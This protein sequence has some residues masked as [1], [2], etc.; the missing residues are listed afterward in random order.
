MAVKL[1][2]ARYG[3]KKYAYY[4]I[5]AADV[6]APRDGRFL[7]QIGTYN[8]NDNPATITLK[9]ERIKHWLSQGATPS[10]TVKNLLDTHLE[11]Q[12]ATEAESK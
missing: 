7:E 8:P 3:G 11:A 12:A 9:H 4:R 10:H 5:V 2:L 1:R 6:R